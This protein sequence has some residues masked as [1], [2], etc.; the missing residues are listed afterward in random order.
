MVTWAWWKWG[1]TANGYK[2]FLGGDG[3]SVKLDVVMFVLLCKFIKNH[4]TVYLT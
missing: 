4:L 3:N 2:R 1:L